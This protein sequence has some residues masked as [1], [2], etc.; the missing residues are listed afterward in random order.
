V[1]WTQRRYPHALT[2]GHL[3]LAVRWSVYYLVVML[4]LLYAHV[5]YTPFI[6]FQF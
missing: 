1:E 4:I 2:I 5:G 6:Y 3:P